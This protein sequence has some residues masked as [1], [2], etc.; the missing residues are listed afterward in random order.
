MLDICLLFE[1]DS[2]SRVYTKSSRPG[3]SHLSV[4][5][6]IIGSGNGLAPLRC[7]VIIWT[8]VDSGSIKPLGTNFNK[9]LINS[10]NF[11][12]GN[13]FLKTS[14]QNAKWCSFCTRSNV[15]SVS[16]LKTIKIHKYKE[17]FAY[18]RNFFSG[19]TTLGRFQDNVL[20][21]RQSHTLRVGGAN[22]DS[23]S[24]A[25]SAWLTPYDGGSQVGMEFTVYTVHTGQNKHIWLHLFE[26]H[27]I[28]I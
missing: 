21:Y 1:R 17:I 4:N 5:R 9:R 24:S 6:V 13:V 27:F 2:F 15:L 12:Q 14:L 19:C 11:P 3:D 20:W 25:N 26:Q 23:F 18:S 8:N 10:R 22:L 16:L 7:H 28:H